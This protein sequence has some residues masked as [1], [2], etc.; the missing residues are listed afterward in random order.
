MLKA[1]RRFFR[2]RRFL[3][4]WGV[5]LA[6]VVLMLVAAF[7]AFSPLDRLNAMVF[8]T[9]QT[10]KPRQSGESP[11]AVID[12]DD[13]SIAAFGQWPWPRDRLADLVDRLTALGAAAIGFDILFSEPDR[14]SPA[15]ALPQ[16]EKLGFQIVRPPGDAGLDHDAVF[17]E[18]IGRAPVVSGLALAETTRAVPPDPKAGVSFGGADPTAYLPSYE[19]SVH[20]LRPIDAAATGIGIISFP[21]GRDGVVRQIPLMSRYDRKLYPALS[22]E[23]LRVAQGASTFLIRSTGAQG[24]L[25]TGEPGMVAIRNGQ[26]NVPTGADGSIWVYY[27]EHSTTPV[28]AAVDLFAD[29]HQAA[30]AEAISGRIVLIGTS[31]IGLRDIVSTPLQSAVPGVFV[32]AEILDQIV[33]GTFISRPDWAVGAEVVLALALS[34][35]VLAF[36]PWLPSLTNG[37]VA[38]V[39]IGIAIAGGWLAFAHHQLLL[40]PML[41]AQCTLL[42]YGVGSGVRLLLSESERRFIRSAF[43]H[44]LA[45]SMVQQLMDNPQALILGGE[46]REITLLFCDIRS[47]TGISERLGP[48]ELTHFLND[49]LTPMTDILMRNGAT[50]DKYMGDAIMAFWNAPLETAEHRRRACRSVV[51][52]EAAL[53]V[54]NQTQPRP[55]AIGIGVNT[56]ICCVG[57]LGSRQRFDYSAIGDPVNVASRAEGMTKQYGLTNL[58]TDSTAEGAAGLAVL[59]VDRVRVY[60]RDKPTPVFTV[61]G[62]EAYARGEDF[63]EVKRIHERFLSRYRARDFE[64]AAHD[65]DILSQTAPAALKGLYEVF[66]ERLAAY[67]LAPPPADWDGTYS[68]TSK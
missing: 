6:S 65:L 21:P 64:A 30:V 25:D 11:A 49:F 14:T 36:L 29:E 62:D 55:V 59:E 35:L 34:T 18:A 26:L 43:S 31:A 3:A 53:A 22:M 20:N 15:L 2:R 9:Y 52:M 7:S 4:V 10:I 39:G 68:A 42:A 56:G 37:L 8:D 67:R 48:I 54:F 27:T 40:S 19:G 17:A 61:L 32:H 5:G 38:A 57:N 60:G 47:F 16:L 23:L 50:I 12:I 33:A 41:P 28:V 44:Y 66:A 45:P 24:E 58:V 1:L 63:Q 13:R 46:N 51:E